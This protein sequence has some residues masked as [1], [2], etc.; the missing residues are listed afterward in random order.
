M[1]FRLKLCRI[2]HLACAALLLLVALVVALFVIPLVKVDPYV[3]TTSVV[4]LAKQNN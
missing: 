3:V 1:S 2:F 4:L